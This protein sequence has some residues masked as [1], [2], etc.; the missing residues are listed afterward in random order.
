MWRLVLMLCLVSA[1]SRKPA[2]TPVVDAGFVVPKPVARLE[3]PDAGFSLAWI[4]EAT[5]LPQVVIDGRA[6]T[7]APAAHYLA[8]AQVDGLFVTRSQNEGEQLVFLSF[9]GGSKPV[10]PPSARARSVSSAGGV[11]LFES[12]EGGLSNLALLDGGQLI[13]HPA[14]SFE[15]SVAPDG[16]WFAFVSSRDGDAEI[17]RAAIDG[18]QLQRLTAFHLDDVA[19][20]ISPDAKWIAF[21]SNRE[22]Q[23]RLFLVKPDGRGQRRLHSEA[24]Q[25]TRWDAGEYEAGEADAVWTPDS[26]ELVFS[27]RGPRG[28]WHLYSA[29][30]ATGSLK[31]L[32]DGAWD[33]QLPALS[34]DGKWIAFVS[35]RDGNAEVYAMPRGGEPRRVTHDAAADWKPLWLSASTR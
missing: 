9:D 32:T 24:A 4:S 26:A 25:D 27:A 17:Y 31:Q 5:G 18:G 8:A 3:L 30:V 2:S 13:T 35:S 29:E 28:Y 16:R 1:C 34:P 11:T 15:P 7:R 22:G 23:D 10:S 33:D 14:G 12:G 6:V 20:K 21:V 19:P